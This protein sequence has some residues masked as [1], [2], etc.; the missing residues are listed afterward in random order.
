M[1]YSRVYTGSVASLHIQV[2]HIEVGVFQSSYVF[3]NNNYFDDLLCLGCACMCSDVYGIWFVCVCVECYSC[4][5]MN[6]VQEEFLQASR[7]A[8]TG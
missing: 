1:L 5:T 7:I 2:V 6:E 4:S 3:L 8:V